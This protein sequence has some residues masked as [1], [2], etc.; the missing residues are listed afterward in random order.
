MGYT[1]HASP[2][3]TSQQKK[4]CIYELILRPGGRSVVQDRNM[5]VEV[6]CFNRSH[7]ALMIGVRLYNK[8][9]CTDQRAPC[10]SRLEA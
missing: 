5:S 4:K 1:P 9:L 8:E 10:S 2:K 6:F 7:C 3:E